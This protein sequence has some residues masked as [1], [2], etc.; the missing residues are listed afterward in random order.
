MK[1]PENITEL[2]RHLEGLDWEY[3]VGGSV[4]ERFRVNGGVLEYRTRDEATWTKASDKTIATFAVAVKFILDKTK[5]PTE[6]EWQKE[7]FDS[8][9]SVGKL[10]QRFLD[11]S[12][13]VIR[14]KGIRFKYSQEGG[15]TTVHEPVYSFSGEMAQGILIG[16]IAGGAEF[17]VGI[18]RPAE[19]KYIVQGKIAEGSW[20]DITSPRTLDEASTSLYHITVSNLSTNPDARQ[21]VYRL[22]RA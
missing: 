16:L 19:P 10:Q 14:A 11:G 9:D 17:E 20:R 1:T 6:I 13:S 18:E 22:R 8:I 3:H 7:D 5:G 4:S 2:L 12:V 15:W 21:F